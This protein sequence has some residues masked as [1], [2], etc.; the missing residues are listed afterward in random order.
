[1]TENRI[2]HNVRQQSNAGWFVGGLYFYADNCECWDKDS[3]SCYYPTEEALMKSYPN[4]IS[5]REACIKA[6][7][8]RWIDWDYEQD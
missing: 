6:K 2:I 5:M 7:Q 8:R 3:E 4:S 1:M